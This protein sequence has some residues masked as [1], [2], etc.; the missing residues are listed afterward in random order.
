MSEVGPESSTE[1][2]WPLSLAASTYQT[3]LT[4][5]SLLSSC[6]AVGKCFS[7]LLNG[8][9]CTIHPG[10]PAARASPLQAGALS[11]VCASRDAA[12]AFL[13]I[14]R[15]ARLFCSAMR[16]PVSLG[17]HED[18]QGRPCTLLTSPSTEPRTIHVCQKNICAWLA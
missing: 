6:Q 7:A 13:C 16:G 18:L 17:G 11:S 14:I 10:T 12:H 15:R 3:L 1:K 4:T 5:Q 9:T 2:K 8:F